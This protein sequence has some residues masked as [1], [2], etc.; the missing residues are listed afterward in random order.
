MVGQFTLYN[1]FASCI[2]EMHRD[3]PFCS[4]AS[5]HGWLLSMLEAHGGRMTSFDYSGERIYVEAEVFDTSHSWIIAPMGAIA[6]KHLSVS[7]SHT[8]H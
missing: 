2:V 7:E 4:L 1:V 3:A 8:V 5:A 6:A